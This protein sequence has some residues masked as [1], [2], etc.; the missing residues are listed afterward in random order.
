MLTFEYY[1]ANPALLR[2]ASSYQVASAPASETTTY[3]R[4]TQWPSC[5]P[6]RDVGNWNSAASSSCHCRIRTT[7]A[8]RI[9]KG[10]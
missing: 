6:F 9:T 3:A 4:V 5:E 10:Q 2:V 7:F 8:P 1:V